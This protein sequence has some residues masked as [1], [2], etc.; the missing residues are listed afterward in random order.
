MPRIA[1]EAELPKVLVK[2]KIS[3][4]REDT[5]GTMADDGLAGRATIG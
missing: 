5:G 2:R 1:L 3:I 4:S